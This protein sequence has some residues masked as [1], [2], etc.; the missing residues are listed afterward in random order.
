[1]EKKV[2]VKSADDYQG[3]MMGSIP[4]MGGQQ[5]SMP[6]MGPP[7][8]MI[9]GFGVPPLPKPNPYVIAETKMKGPDTGIEITFKYPR[10]KIFVG[11]LDF[12]LTVDEL[13]QH[14]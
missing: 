13:R 2:D 10:S 4:G 6:G 7:M 3:K 1:M 8:G 11:G 14:F 9:P 5:P 12:N